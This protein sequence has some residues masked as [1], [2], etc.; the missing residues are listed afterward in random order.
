MCEFS[1]TL[2]PEKPIPLISEMTQHELLESR[3]GEW[4]KKSGS[5]QI[6]SP[7]SDDIG[8][9]SITPD[10]DNWQNNL[11]LAGRGRKETRVKP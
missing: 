8:S 3:D 7:L 4:S 1:L 6:T 11:P 10:L 5:H 9:N 2:P